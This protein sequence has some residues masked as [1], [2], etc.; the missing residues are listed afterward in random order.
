[1]YVMYNIDSFAPSVRNIVFNK[2]VLSKFQPRYLLFICNKEF[3]IQFTIS[4]LQTYS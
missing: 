2:S 4:Y 1:M 3:E